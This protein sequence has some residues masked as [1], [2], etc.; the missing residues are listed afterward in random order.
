[1]ALYGCMTP[2]QDYAAPRCTLG[3]I[4]LP[5]RYLGSGSSPRSPAPVP[6]RHDRDAAA[7]LGCPGAEVGAVPR[8][9]VPHLE[10]A[11]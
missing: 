10:A 2:I 1:M 9:G 8:D 5:L 6:G 11:R 3:G 7:G 4:S